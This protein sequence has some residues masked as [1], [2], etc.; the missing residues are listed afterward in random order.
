MCLGLA[1]ARDHLLLLLPQHHHLFLHRPDFR[2]TPKQKKSSIFLTLKPIFKL[3]FSKHQFS[4]STC[5]EASFCHLLQLPIR[6]KN[7][8]LKSKNE[9]FSTPTLTMGNCNTRDEASVLTPQAQAQ[10][11][12]QA[13]GLSLSLSFSF[14]LD[15]SNLTPLILI[16]LSTSQLNSYREN[17][18]APSQI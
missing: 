15:L 12:A 9:I 10:A 1:G 18:H 4:Q 2:H 3:Y 11:Q 16:Y 6:V 5:E 17:T 7:V 8:R 14:S 13:Q